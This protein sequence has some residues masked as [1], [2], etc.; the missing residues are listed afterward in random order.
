[1]TDGYQQFYE[2]WRGNEDSTGSKFS[3]TFP[4]KLS[5]GKRPNGVSLLPFHPHASED[6][7][8]VTNSYEWI[9]H[10]LLGLRKGDTDRNRGAV[11]IGQPGIGAALSITRSPPRAMTHRRIRSPGKTTF[12]KFMLARLIS[13]HQV[14]LLCG[15]SIAHLFYRGQVYS[16]STESCFVNLPTC[17]DS[18]YCPIWA[19]V[20]MDLRK[21]EPPFVKN[22]NFWPIQTASPDNFRWATWRKQFG[23]ALLGMPLWDMKELMEG[24]VFSS[25]SLSVIDP[26]HVA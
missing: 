3:N 6:R 7:I 14:V 18:P 1:M 8:L 12:L 21:Q 9:F 26:G 17:E 20:D 24:Y 23:A 22:I 16:R 25:F 5:L 15:P 13:L 4:Y 10:R 19:L 11:L 2:H